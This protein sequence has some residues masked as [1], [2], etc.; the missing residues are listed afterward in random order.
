MNA[1]LLNQAMNLFDKYEKFSAFIELSNARGEIRNRYFARLKAEIFSYSINYPWS[2][3][4][5][6]FE[7]YRWIL[8]EFKQGS[9]CLV[10]NCWHF[11]LWC[12]PAI[13]DVVKIKELLATPKFEPIKGCFDYIDSIS[14]PN[15]HHFFEEKH[16]FEFSENLSYSAI[17]SENHEK[18]SWFA[19]NKTKEMGNLIMNKVNKFRMPEITELLIDLNRE[20]KKVK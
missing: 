5:D 19:G 12:D 13:Y 8:T 15:I 17:D 3:T 1:E 16:R 18:L 9:I 4:A 10:W 11:K 7:Q 20:G 14:Q 2:V 6:N